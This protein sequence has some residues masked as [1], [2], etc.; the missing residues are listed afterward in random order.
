MA[1][2]NSVS[3]VLESEPTLLIPETAARP[4]LEIV[5]DLEAR[6]RDA[7]ETARRIEDMLEG[8]SGEMLDRAVSGHTD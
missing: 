8:I 2:R 3:P 4:L 6:T 7:L 5:R 1:N